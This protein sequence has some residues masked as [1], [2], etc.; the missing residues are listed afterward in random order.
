VRRVRYLLIGLAAWGV[1]PAAFGAEPSGAAKPEP[2]SLIEDRAAGKLIEAGLA[3]LEAD[4]PSKA[5]E[6][7]QSVMERYPRSRVRFHAHML[8]GKHF[9]E[10]ERAYERARV[11]F[12]LAASKENRDEDQR[13]EAMMRTGAC[14]YHLRN[15]GK[16]FQVMRDMI[17]MFPASPYVND[18]YY[19]IGLG[20]FQLGHYSR[21]ISALENVGTAI[22]TEKGKI[23]KLE[24]G[25]RLFVRIEDADHGILDPQQ[26]IE[27]QC[28]S[29]SGDREVV[30]CYL[31]ARNTRLAIGSIPTRLDKPSPGNGQLEVKGDDK[32]KLTYIDQHTAEREMNRKVERTVEVVGT[33]TVRITDGAF[34]ESLLGAVLGKDLNLQ[35]TDADRDLTDKADTVKATVFVYRPKTDEE[36]ENEA[37]QAKAEA[38]V[39]PAPKPKAAPAAA[40]GE[41][42]PDVLKE[43]DRREIVL[44]EVRLPRKVEKGLEDLKPAAPPREEQ[45]SSEK[46]PQAPGATKPQAEPGKPASDKP[47]RVPGT[48]AEPDEKGTEA[49]AKPTETPAVK[50]ASPAPSPTA[51]EEKADD[52]IHSGY[53]RLSLPLEKAE[54]AIRGDEKLQA[55]PGDLIRVVYLD[56]RHRGEGPREVTAQAR[57]LEGNIGAVRVSHANI[58]DQ[59][60]R[61]QT[62]LKTASALTNIGNRYKEFGLKKNADDKYKQALT[63]C[64]E[65]MKEAAKLGGRVLEETYVQLWRIYFEMERL[66]LAAAMCQRLQQQFPSSGFVDEALLQLAEVARKQNDLNRAIHTYSSLLAVRTSPL[67]G[68]AQFGIAQCYD[69]MAKAAEGPQTPALRA[70]AFEEYKKVFDQFPD[71][72]RV[73]DAV[74]KMADYYYDQKDYA[75]ATEVFENVIANHPDAK[76]LDVI[77]FNYGRCLFRMDRKPQALAKFEQLLG[78]FPDSSLA[79]DTKEIIAAM[80]KKAEK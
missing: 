48:P 67:R 22:T 79:A 36:L 66:D 40:N 62:E 3:R 11:H 68:E 60:L 29:A 18:A 73:G 78:E 42:K 39:A 19:Y 49:K 21:A 8:L 38:A 6:I 45:A 57:C 74:A 61:I 20:H 1:G 17:D 16:C 63:V 75:R 10:R 37:V 2:G 32:V 26:A 9:L 71:S 4:E 15:H 54:K 30:K 13:A 72:G 5:V 65:I 7:W 52:S 50:P 51:G 69:Q 34:A 31:I 59:E 76:F 70:R 77:L 43:I 14:Y 23:E 28:E 24:A 55:L 64:E 47:A 35:V 33:A 46:A 12:E 25:K 80:R 56:E 41:E 53:F 44:T 58:S 27:V